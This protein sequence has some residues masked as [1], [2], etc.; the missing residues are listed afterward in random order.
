MRAAA[1]IPIAVERLSDALGEKLEHGPARKRLAQL[2][3]IARRRD[4]AEDI[5]QRVRWTGAVPARGLS[6]WQ[7]ESLEWLRIDEE[8]R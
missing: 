1:S 8:E 2:A 3:F 6:A 5:R 4:D 7:E